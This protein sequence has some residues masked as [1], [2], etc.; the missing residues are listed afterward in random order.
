MAE[1]VCR[2][3]RP[4]VYSIGDTHGRGREV[5]DFIHTL[6][7]RSISLCEEKPVFIQLG[8]LCDC[9]ALPSAESLRDCLERRIATVNGLSAAL[10]NG[11]GFVDWRLN[12]GS[13]REGQVRAFVSGA[14]LLNSEDSSVL[15]S[16]Y[17]ATMSFETLSVYSA[18]QSTRPDDFVVIFGNHDADLLRGR[19]DYGRQQKYLLWGLLGFTPEETVAH[20]LEGTPS[21]MM[22]HP[23]IRWL[24]ERPHLAIAEDAVYMH[25]GPTGKLSSELR[26]GGKT[27]F[28]EWVDRLAHARHEGWD[29]PA[30]K[31]HECFLSPDGADNDWV[32]HPETI[33]DFCEAAGVKY[34]AVGHSPFLDFE[35]GPLIDLARAE[36]W[37]HLF[38][39]P[40]QLPP[41]GRL[42]K[43]DTNL[44]RGGELWACYHRVGTDVWT[45]IDVAGQACEL[46]HGSGLDVPHS[47]RTE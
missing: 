6:E 46:R 32:H 11:A 22:R 29:H 30:F 8:D 38:H 1:Y 47:D 23:W 5:V 45:G 44:K 33:E 3:D 4:H 25:G 26:D 28:G 19:S 10:S 17:E 13:L 36:S 12:P 42:I 2:I 21:V 40:A 18:L 34:L 27:S 20:M 43:H 7:A 14:D 41:E 9:F 16:L 37:R 35:K 24:N 31:E 15:A 39:T